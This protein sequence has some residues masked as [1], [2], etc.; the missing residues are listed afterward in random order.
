MPNIFVRRIADERC[1]WQPEINYKEV[2]GEG[3]NFKYTSKDLEL[4]QDVT[5]K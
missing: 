2:R 4:G 1:I 3:A 5:R